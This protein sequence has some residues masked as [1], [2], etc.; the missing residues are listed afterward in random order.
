MIPVS[1]INTLVLIPTFNERDNVQIIVKRVKDSLPSAH[2]L[3]IDDS[4]PDGTGEILDEMSNMDPTIHIEHRGRKLG[5]GSAHLHGIN[6]AFDHGVDVLITLDADLTHSPEDANRMMTELDHA[7]VIVG[8]R[9]IGHGG[10]K[11]WNLGRKVMTHLGHLLTLILLRIPHDA[12]GGF[13]VY[14]I[15]KLNR[16][17]F[18][19]VSSSNYSFFFESLKILHLNSVSI[20]QVP[21]VLPARTYGSSKMRAKDIFGSF[22][23]L[24]KLS[25]LTTM[26]PNRYRIDNER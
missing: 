19:L 7:D 18:E 4:S 21:I 5:V 26:V 12:S 15:S 6:W 11:D 2:L 25:I 24:L 10:V 9:F 22:A 16:K 17:V 8:S 23:Y 14:K 20:R 3:F 13:R 1:P